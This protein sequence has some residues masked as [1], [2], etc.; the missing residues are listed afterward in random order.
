[1]GIKRERGRT[2]MVSPLVLGQSG[3]RMEKNRVEDRIKMVR[4]MACGAIGVQMEPYVGK[5]TIW[6]DKR[7][8]NGYNGSMTEQSGRR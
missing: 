6:S 7:M 1:M 8:A 2:K 5:A 4:S 3:M